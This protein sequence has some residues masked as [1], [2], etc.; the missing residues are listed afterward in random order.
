[1]KKEILI[2]GGVVSFDWRMFG[3]LGSVIWLAK[4]GFYGFKRKG[5][6]LFYSFETKEVRAVQKIEDLS[7]FLKPALKTI[8][9]KELAQALY[10]KDYFDKEIAQIFEN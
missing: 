5:V 1:M 10:Q 2:I 6:T 3:E 8:S 9:K 7:I 4:S